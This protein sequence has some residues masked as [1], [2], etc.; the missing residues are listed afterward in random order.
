M[1]K[2]Q[3]YKK[4]GLLYIENY[5]EKSIIP[6]HIDMRQLPPKKDK[7]NRA[8]EYFVMNNMF[9][10]AVISKMKVESFLMMVN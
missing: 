1:E 6:I 2:Q 4:I 8:T 5:E 9:T 3:S 10:D 7:L